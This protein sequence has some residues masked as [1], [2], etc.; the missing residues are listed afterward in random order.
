[1]E[2]FKGVGSHLGNDPNKN[3]FF[4]ESTVTKIVMLAS[5]KFVLSEV[6][7][8]DKKSIKVYVKNFE[9]TKIALKVTFENVSGVP[10]LMLRPEMRL[11]LAVTS[12]NVDGCS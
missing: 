1:M 6:P 11:V 12:L 9:S 8:I 5:C 7:Q 4:L 10:F 3:F 2:D